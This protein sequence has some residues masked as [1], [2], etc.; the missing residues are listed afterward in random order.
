MPL[1]QPLDPPSLQLTYIPVLP[2]KLLDLMEAPGSFLYGLCTASLPPSAIS[3]IS[4]GLEGAIIADLDNNRVLLG[5]LEED[6]L[7]EDQ[8]PPLPEPELGHLRQ[9][10][11][12]LLAPE[13][14]RLDRTQSLQGQA[15]ERDDHLS[16]K[17]WGPFHDMQV[18]QLF[19]RFFASTLVGYVNFLDYAGEG[20]D[21]GSTSSGKPI[22]VF[23]KQA[24]I[25]KQRMR[26]SLPRVCF[27]SVKYLPQPWPKNHCN[28]RQT[29][30]PSL[31][32]RSPAWT[33]SRRLTQ[34]SPLSVDL[35]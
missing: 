21:G 24:F 31:G 12:R 34:T 1:L 2:V 22:V 35:N 13:R 25:K 27:N 10:L 19:L 30:A 28:S 8:L 16:R 23:N 14:E 15:V 26:S 11:Q 17:P 5:G 18:R 9:G 29:L 7:E 32:D 20:G 33:M 4:Q 3:G 6:Q